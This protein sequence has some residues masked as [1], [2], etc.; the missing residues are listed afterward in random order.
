MKT[1]PVSRSNRSLVNLSA[2]VALLLFLLP[3]VTRADTSLQVG[4]APPASANESNNTAFLTWTAAAGGNYLV[5]SSTNISDPAAWSTAD[6]VSQ[7]TVGPLKWMAPESLKEQKYYR[8]VLPK[9]QIFSVEPAV[10]EPGAPVNFVVIGQDLGTNVVLLIN[11]VPQTNVVFQGST[12]MS[13]PTFVPDVPGTYQVTLMVGGA[14][15][16]SFNVTCADALANPELVLQGP[17]TMEPP[18]SPAKKDFRGHVTLLKAFDDD[19]DSY[20]SHSHTKTGHVTLLKAFDDGSDDSERTTKTGHV[21][22]MKAFDDGGDSFKTHTKTGHVT[23]L[24]AF[25]DGGDD[26][27]ARTTK[28]GHVTLMKAFD[29]GSD[30][31]DRDFATLL[32]PA[33]MK[34][35][36]KANQ[37]RFMGGPGSGGGMATLLMPAL[38]KAKEKANQVKCGS[39][40][41]RK[42]GAI[43]SADF[44]YRNGAGRGV[45]PFSG[46]VQECDVDMAIPGRELDFVWARTYHSRIGRFG[47]ATN[48]WTFSYDVRCTQNS[49]GGMDVYDGSGRKDTFTRQTTGV[50]TC[51]EMFREGAI[52][53]SAFTLTFADTGRWVFNPF[54][55]TAT[56][57]KLI[58]IITR[59]GNTMTLG[60]DTSGRLAQIVDDLGRTNTMA[61]NTAGQIGSVTDFTGRS[62]TYQYYAGAKSDNGSAGDLQSVTSPPVTGTPNGNDFPSG[63]TT[64]YTY[65]KNFPLDRENH[66]LLTVTNPDGQSAAVFSYEHT[67]SA[68]NYLH[69]IS[70]QEGTNTPTVL[71]YKEL[72]IHKPQFPGTQACIANDPV[73]NVTQY[74][75]DARNRCI[76]EDDYTGRATPG[77]PVTDTSNQPTGPVRSTD[78]AYYE[79]TWSWNNDSLC[80]SETSPGGQQMQYVYQSDFDPSTT[81]R[82]RADCRVVRELASSAVDLNGDGIPDVTSRACYFSYDPRF[83]ADF[84]IGNHKDCVGHTSYPTWLGITK[85]VWLTYPI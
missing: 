44:N 10:I 77:V 30:D 82:K 75:F 51:P 31:L 59:N 70:M 28:T 9:P 57:G 15:V 39:V 2:G 71:N 36:E 40:Y 24:K 23:L 73:G 29:D 58:Q 42:D 48:G 18:A 76:A 65:S 56:A 6:A 55:G 45:A 85:I 8:L 67:A 26:S 72:E 7:N 81:A 52:S 34:A 27:S 19:G 14:V 20:S 13:P 78:P 35:K 62:V 37:T 60:Y 1:Q 22:L 16:S 79:T 33:L 64:T 12:T 25:D 11:G 63:K 5:Q 66:L 84:L 83:G 21:T 53:N 38:M 3:A 80:T 54:D 32:M 50:Y 74:Y 43:L 61:Y 41:K 46:E 4:I 17:P 69:C 68:T 47:S 49:A